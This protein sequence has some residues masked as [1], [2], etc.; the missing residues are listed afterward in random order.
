MLKKISSVKHIPKFVRRAKNKNN[1]FR[2]ISFSHRVYKNYN[3][4]ATVMRKTCH[5]VLKKLSTKNNLLKV[6]IKLKNIALNNPYFI[7]K[8]LYPNVNF[9]SSIILKAISIP[10][11]MFTVIFAI[12]RTVG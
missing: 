12:A 5:K 2:L 6:A 1:S 10:S 3:P 9:Y 11:S 8:K 4:R 7:K